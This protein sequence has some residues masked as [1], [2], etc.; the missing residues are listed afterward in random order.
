MEPNIFVAA[1]KIWQELSKD[2]I[3]S[4]LNFELEIHR[5]LLNIF[6][7]GD[8]YYMIFNVRDAV[9]DVVSR[10]ITDLLGYL[11]E[12][13][14]VP[15]FIGNIHPEDQPWFLNFENKVRE[16]FATLR[17]N[18]VPNYKVRYDYRIRKKNGD[19]IRILQQVIT[20]QHDGE[21]KILRTLVVHTDISHIKQEGIPLL[22]FIGMNGEPSYINIDVAKVFHPQHTVL[23]E[24]EREIVG[25]LIEGKDSR[26]I[27]ESLHISK[28]TVDTHRKNILRKT[29]SP[30]TAALINM[31]VKK[32]WV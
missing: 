15:F 2:S 21:N 28:Q 14:N 11:P 12:E 9:F 4:D 13:I 20:I 7:V 18:Q 16:F 17:H 26:A 10:E 32:G 23:T 30:N 25:L 27:G 1:S 31:A 8:Y 3:L 24:R 6:Q 29:E 22:S 5:K 19:Y